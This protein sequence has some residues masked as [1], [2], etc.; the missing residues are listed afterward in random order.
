MKD[1]PNAFMTWVLLHARPSQIFGSGRKPRCINMYLNNWMTLYL[2]RSVPSLSV[3]KFFL[4]SWIQAK[5]HRTHFVIK[6]ILFAWHLK[7]IEPIL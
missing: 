6:I 7:D 5:D 4:H 2:P 3:M 1:S